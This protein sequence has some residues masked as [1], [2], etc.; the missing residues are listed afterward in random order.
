MMAKDILGMYGRNSSQ[1]QA[2]KN[3]NGGKLSPK[4]IR[5]SPPVGPKGISDPKAPGLHGSNHGNCVK[6]GRH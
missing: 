6:Q 1:P 2:A 4:P 5:Y 3:T